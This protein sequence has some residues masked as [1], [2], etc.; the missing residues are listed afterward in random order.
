MFS[1]EQSVVCTLR[2][3]LLGKC[4]LYGLYKEVNISD[5]AGNEGQLVHRGLSRAGQ[6]ETVD[7]RH[8]IQLN[9]AN[10]DN[11]ALRR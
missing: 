10:L 3:T 2:V 9:A 7:Y 11:P 8:W 1:T 6:T 4:C 5:Y